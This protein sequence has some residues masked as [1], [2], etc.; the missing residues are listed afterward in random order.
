MVLYDNFKNE[1]IWY[2][3]IY[4]SWE[5]SKHKS[6]SHWGV[7]CSENNKKAGVAGP[8][9][10][11]YRVVGDKGQWLDSDHIMQHNSNSSTVKTSHKNRFHF[12]RRPIQ[13]VLYL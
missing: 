1:S 2:I 13:V 3:S 7:A 10:S 4:V 5:K 8:D 6:L 12:D 11:R 9:W